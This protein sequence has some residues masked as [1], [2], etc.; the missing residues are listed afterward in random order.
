MTSI[1]LLPWREKARTYQKRLFFAFCGAAAGVALV[2]N[3]IWYE[4]LQHRIDQQQIRNDLLQ[5]ELDATQKISQS[6]KK[7]AEEKTTTLKK[8]HTLL[9]LNNQ[10]FRVVDLLE[11]LPHLL[12]NGM[13]IEAISAD[14]GVYTLKG[15]AQNDMQVS[16]T[17]KRLQQQAGWGTIQL[18]EMSSSAK[19]TTTFVLTIAMD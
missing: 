2:I 17:I 8:M 9:E 1:N 4:V 18:Q 5:Q 10:R 7:F 11:N 16:E 13:T 6:K 3:G 19:N 15:E 12:P 14:N